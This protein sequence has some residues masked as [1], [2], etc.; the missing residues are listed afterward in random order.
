MSL[1]KRCGASPEVVSKG[2]VRRPLAGKIDMECGGS[3][4]LLT[5]GLDR[6]PLFAIR[7]S[8]VYSHALHLKPSLRERR[9]EPRRP[10]RRRAAALQI[11]TKSYFVS[12]GF[13]LLESF[14]TAQE[15]SVKE[16]FEGPVGLGAEGDFGAEGV[17]VTRADLR[18]K[19]GNAFS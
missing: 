5:G 9:V 7:L 16:Q 13:R 2:A 17:E 4:P 6:P 15:Q 14:P 10:K 19:R 1:F 12:S 3:T 8:F 18:A 11:G